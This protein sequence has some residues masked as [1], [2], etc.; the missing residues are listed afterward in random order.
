MIKSEYIKKNKWLNGQNARNEKKKSHQKTSRQTNN[1][2]LLILEN[3]VTWAC[4]II[5]KMA[6][7]LLMDPKPN[8]YLFITSTWPQLK[9][10]ALTLRKHP[11]W[12]NFFNPDLKWKTHVLP[13]L[14]VKWLDHSTAPKGI[15]LPTQSSTC[16]KAKYILW[17]STV[18][19]FE[20]ELL[21]VLFLHWQGT[22]PP[23]KFIGQSCFLHPI[24]RRH[25]ESLCSIV[26]F[27]SDA[28]LSF[29][30]YPP[31]TL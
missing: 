29:S 12:T 24:L 4:G 17:W 28:R 6:G 5:K 16:I 8:L 13:M 14:L 20:E 10:T 30:L 18:A 27:I 19:T 15:S 21:G 3:S 25:C 7:H 23:S 1:L 2:F 9:R 22:K 31:V 26:I 11:A